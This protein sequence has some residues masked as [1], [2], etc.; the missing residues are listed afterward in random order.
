VPS[1]RAPAGADRVSCAQCGENIKLHW[2]AD[3]EEWVLLD[4]VDVPG[5]GL[6]HYGCKP[7]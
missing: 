4:A 6:C 2:D 1:L 5:L 3:A 7:V